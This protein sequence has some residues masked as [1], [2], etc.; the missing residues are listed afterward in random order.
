MPVKYI[1]YII[2]IKVY[3]YFYSQ[4]LQGGHYNA[5]APN[6]QCLPKFYIVTAK[7][8]V[9][10]LTK[11]EKP[12]STKNMCDNSIFTMKSNYKKS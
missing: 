12:W 6:M 9:R 4:L 5:Y 11:N 2:C 7:Y 10:S 1:S 3:L 8:F